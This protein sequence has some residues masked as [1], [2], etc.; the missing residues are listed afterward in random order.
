MENLHTLCSKSNIGAQELY[1]IIESDR[2]LSR[3]VLRMAHRISSN[4]KSLANAFIVLGI[5]TIK[6]I[7]LVIS[8]DKT[9]GSKKV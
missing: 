4:L 8:V 1:S 6:N 3:E 2:E 5:N 7:V 9:M